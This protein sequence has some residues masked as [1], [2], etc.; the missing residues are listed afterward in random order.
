[1]IRSYTPT[2]HPSAPKASSVVTPS[3]GD[4]FQGALK[5]FTIS[6]DKV[7]FHE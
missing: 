5:S 2:L 4:S 1:M 6:P 3:N 7:S